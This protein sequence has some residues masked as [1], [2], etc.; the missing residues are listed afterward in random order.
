MP[1]VPLPSPWSPRRE[2]LS[3]ARS[4]PPAPESNHHSH[5]TDRIY[6]TTTLLR[7]GTALAGG[8]L[9]ESQ[10]TEPRTLT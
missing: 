9:I 2:S 7:F 3:S 5:Q 10:R 8:D 4:T 1:L 6:Q